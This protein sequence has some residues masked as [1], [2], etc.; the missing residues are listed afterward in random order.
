MSPRQHLG[1]VRLRSRSATCIWDW[2]PDAGARSPISLWLHACSLPCHPSPTSLEAF[3]D[4]RRP[5]RQPITP[6]RSLKR[7]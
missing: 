4:P 7:G 2:L 3:F 6:R 1:V 5:W